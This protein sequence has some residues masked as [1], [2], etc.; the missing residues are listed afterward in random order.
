[1]KFFQL[2]FL[3]LFFLLTSHSLTA[4]SDLPIPKW[5]FIDQAT[6]PTPTDDMPVYAQLLYADQ[7]N[8]IELE[9]AFKAYYDQRGWDKQFEDLEHDP[10]A[11]FYNR[12]YRAAQ[13]YIDDNGIVKTLN[14]EELIRYRA[15][16]E[17]TEDNV[18]SN[19]LLSPSSS[20][21]FLGPKRTYWR[22]DHNPGL[23]APW[24]VNIYTVTVAPS[25]PAI[26]YAGSETGALY[27]SIDKG[28]N[29]TPFDDFNWGRA[30]LSVEIHPTDPSIVYAATSTDIFKTTDGGASWSI[31]LTESGLSCNSLAISPSTPTT[32]FAGTSNGLYRSTDSGSNWTEM[33]TEQIDDVLFRPNDGSTIYVLARTGS[34]DTYSFYKSTDSGSTFNLSMTGWGTIYEQSGGRMTVTPADDDYIYVTLLTHDGSGGDQKPY[35]LKSTDAAA[36]WTTVATGQTAN[37]EM[38]NGQG[39][40]DLDVVA[41]HSN[42]DHIITATTT[43]YKSTDGGI[44]YTAIGGYA[45]D[46]AIHPDIQCM[47]SIMDGAT[48]DTWLSTDGGLNYSSDFYT[49]TANWEARIDGLDG[50]DFWGFAQGWNEDYLIGGRY[51]NGNTVIHEN[52]PDQQALRLGGAESPT[53][54]AMHG[55]ERHAAFDDISE[56]IIPDD[57]NNA[58]EGSFLFTKHPN[59]YYY[60]DAFGRVLIDLEDFM[61]VYTGSGNDFWKSQDGGASWESTYGFSG[62][63]YHFDISRADANYF[64]LTTDDGFYRSTDRGETFTEMTL[65]PGL[66][67]WHSQNLRVAASSTNREVVWVL[68]QRSGGGSSAGRVFKSIDGGASWTDLTTTALTPNK[69]T[70]IAHQAGTN[71]GVYIACNRGDAGTNPA[72]V[73]YRD[74]SMS[75]WVDFSDNLPQSA[76]PIKLLPFYKQNKLRWGGNRGAWEIDFYEEN[77][78]PIAQPFVSGKTQICSRDTVEFDSYSVA[79]ESA[80][81]SWNIPGASWTSNLNQRE[82]KAIFPSE[83]TYT[84]TLTI[85][86]AGTIDDK[87]ITVTINNECDPEATPGN[88]LTLTGESS[89]YASTKNALDITTNNM[90]MS[91]WI[92]RNGDQESYA[93]IIFMRQTSSGGL[94]F[95]DNNE[96]GFHWN[97][98]Q[99]WWSSG[100]TV[101]DNEWAHVAMV[102]SPTETTLYLNGEPAVNTADN[103]PLAFDGV[104]NFGADP[105]WSARRFKGEMDE[106]VVYN[107]A[108]DQNEIRELMHLTRTPANETDLIGYWQF[109]RT[110]GTITDRAGSNHASLI[111]GATRST[112]SV[113]VGPGES[114][115]LDVTAAGVYTFGT[116]DLTLEFPSGGSVF[117]DGELCVTRIDHAPDQSPQE[118]KISDSYWVVRNFGNNS[119]FDELTSLTFDGLNVTNEEA[120][121]LDNLMLYKRISGGD[122]A[123]W[124]D[125]EDH[126][127]MATEGTTDGSITFSTGNGQTSFS[128]FIISFEKTIVLPA[129]LLSFNVVLNNQK[130]VAL[131]WTTASEE[132]MDHYEIQRSQDG[133]SFSF[134]ESIDLPEDSETTKSYQAFDKNPFRGLSYYRLKMVDLDG[135]V[136]YSEI[137]SIVINALADKVI[138]YPNPIEVGQ[139]LQIKTELSGTIDLQLYSIDGEEAG[140]YRFEGDTEISLDHLPKGVYSY[141][142]NNATWRKAGI[143]IIK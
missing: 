92:K 28:L 7:V 114:A 6:I 130:E 90:T 4:Q 67:N 17:F 33:L 109:N 62:K 83:G 137:K 122:G 75:D 124:G 34:P 82:V 96:L 24:Q 40:Y 71:G 80:T 123:T 39:Y 110:S 108:L 52:Y 136:E 127:D 31:I 65:P 134:L 126:A 29:W 43:A 107:R 91:A 106:V 56:L 15:D 12:W 54:W 69:W 81:Y 133:R 141:V 30:I 53:G 73:L 23:V 89:D 143:L 20:W 119:S 120:N 14:T 48:E 60:G 16:A 95:R 97:N 139:L 129:D 132:N 19:S 13:N 55:R 84:A 85:N 94:N 112:S 64:Y 21:S 128:Q 86:Q 9:Q 118:N 68:N 46:F 63:P 88:A 61:T 22:A 5:H 35:I 18:S 98:S 77:W 45:G 66:T 50:T 117:P 103:D 135:S 116:T 38:T 111:G 42:A 93:G 58:P 47:I 138:I 125:S 11:K 99:W 76:N 32:I 44:T 105:N 10:F 27:K 3:S 72:K 100:L 70:S 49:N 104:L 1:M 26:L 101:P 79:K 113:P 36:N 102:I 87:S 41:S 142:V 121:D 59:I 140:E 115:R 78:S 57:I 25:N 2:T 74:D 51:H 8:T 131:K 37:L